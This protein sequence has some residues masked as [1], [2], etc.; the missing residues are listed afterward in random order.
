[1]DQHL[2]IISFDIPWPPNYGGVIDVFYKIK[3]LSE[4]GVTFIFIAL[5]IT[6]NRIKLLKRFVPA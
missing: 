6:A 1:M 5:S 3:T 4:A 2:H